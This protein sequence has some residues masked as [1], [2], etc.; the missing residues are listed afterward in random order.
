[1]AAGADSVQETNIKEDLHFFLFDRNT[2][3]PICIE[4]IGRTYPHPE[5]RIERK[6]SNYFVLEY[7][8]SGKG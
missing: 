8:I 2:S 3:L 1:M 6:N 4:N 7:V 5:Y